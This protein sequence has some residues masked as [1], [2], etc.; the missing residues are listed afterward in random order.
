MVKASRSLQGKVKASTGL[1]GKVEASMGT[2]QRTGAV[3]T[4]MAVSAS[5]GAG[6]VLSHASRTRCTNHTCKEHVAAGSGENK[7]VYT[8]SVKSMYA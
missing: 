8:C 1:Q 3:G 7:H 6:L 4:F 5:P 2:T